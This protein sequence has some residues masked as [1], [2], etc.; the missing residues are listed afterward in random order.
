M[1]DIGGVLFGTNLTSSG[2]TAENAQARRR[3]GRGG[4]RRPQRLPPPQDQVIPG[5]FVA[6]AQ[7]RGSL[8]K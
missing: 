1:N 4:V 6:L 3:D 7:T 2:I 8:S 5:F